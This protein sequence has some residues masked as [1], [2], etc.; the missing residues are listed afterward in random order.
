MVKHVGQFATGIKMVGAICDHCEA[1]VCHLR[2][3]LQSHC[4]TCPLD[5]V[6]CIEC[7]RAVSEH[8]GRVFR[9]SFCSEGLCE[10]DQF[11]HQ[12]NCQKL[13]SES[14]KCMSCNKL[15]QFSCLRCKICF[16]DDHVRRKGVKVQRGQAIPC[17]KCG[18]NTSETK[19]LSVSTKTLQYGKQGMSY[20]DDDDDDDGGYGGG[21]EFSYGASSITYGDDDDDEDDDDKEEDDDDEE[22]EEDNEVDGKIEEKNVER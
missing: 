10:D 6:V 14:Y 16:C 19:D 22:E 7:N 20:G 13:D 1:W 12:A 8:G 11:E 18:Y 15:G 17:P 5:G 2:K 21:G 3:C 9:C 4:C